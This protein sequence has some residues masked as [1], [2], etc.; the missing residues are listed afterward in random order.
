MK[1][2]PEAEDRDD[3]HPRADDG[4]LDGRLVESQDGKNRRRGYSVNLPSPVRDQLCDRRDEGC[5]RKADLVAELK[6]GGALHFPESVLASRSRSFRP[7]RDSVK[8]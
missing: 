6:G 5:G 3:V 1:N 7:R 4:R 8:Q 2:E